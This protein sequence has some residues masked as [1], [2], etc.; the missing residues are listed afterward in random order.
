MGQVAD[1]SSTGT[2][3]SAPAVPTAQP[4]AAPRIT[5]AAPT[6]AG[7]G[8]VYSY[9]IQA[10]ASSSQTITFSLGFAPAGMSVNASTGLVTWSPTVLQTGSTAVT[11][12]ATDQF[13][14]TVRQAFSISVSGAFSRSNP[15]GPA[16]QNSL[17]IDGLWPASL[18]SNAL[19]QF[20]VG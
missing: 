16:K 1:P 4:V 10:S 13:G 5:S 12:L 11:V 6:Q 3:P 18:K 20:F 2:D 8:H 14:N 17:T 7:V 19:D 15:F 9:Q